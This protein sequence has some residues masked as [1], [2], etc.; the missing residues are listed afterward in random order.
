M[1]MYLFDGIE[2]AAY[3]RPFKKGEKGGWLELPSA[4]VSRMEGSNAKKQTKW[5]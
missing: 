1:L 4:L 5:H 2:G 3:C